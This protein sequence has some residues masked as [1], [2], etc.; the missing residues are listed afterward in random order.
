MEVKD[1]KNQSAKA[2]VEHTEAQLKK[3][4]PEN[5]SYKEQDLKQF[6]IRK[7]SVDGRKKPELYYVYT[8]DLIVAN[9]EHVKKFPKGNY[10]LFKKKLSYSRT[11]RQKLR[12]RP[13]VIG[14]GPAGLFCVFTCL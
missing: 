13:V 12:K 1:A 9:E 3:E 10:K 14:S 11:R 2:P 7:R 4:T 5:S 8:V 6:F